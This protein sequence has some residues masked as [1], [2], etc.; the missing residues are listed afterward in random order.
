MF[1]YSALSKAVADR[2]AELDR[3]MQIMNDG[4]KV[5]GENLASLAKTS[6]GR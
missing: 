3:D 5:V 4:M 2:R 6:R 1:S